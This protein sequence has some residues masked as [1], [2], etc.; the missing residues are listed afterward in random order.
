MNI[1]QIKPII[2]AAILAAGEPISFER[3]R[4]LFEET[5]RP[6]TGDLCAAL[7]ELANDCVG[8]GIELKEVAS[9]FCFQA[10]T[11]LSPW[12]KRLWQE[13]PPRYSRAFMETLAVIAY[14][15]PITRP[16]IEDIRGVAVSS[17]II[18][19]LLEREWVRIV[20][21][22]EVPGRP[23][24]FG[25]TRQFLDHFSLKSLDG[26]PVLS[27]LS[28]LE[29]VANRLEEH[30]PVEVSVVAAETDADANVEEEVSEVM[31]EEIIDEATIEAIAET[32]VE[33]EAEA[34]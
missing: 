30:M 23:S 9:G 25:T 32:E 11:E 29:Q 7:A 34:A 10:K 13:R 21:Q 24:L 5:E 27:E 3:L 17:N 19:T 14:R 22:R 26:L 18:K 2:E 6:A 4:H 8:R 33:T 31:I 16:E 12:I 15:Q 28:D 20:G 1:E